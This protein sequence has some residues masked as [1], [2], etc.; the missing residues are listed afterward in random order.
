MLRSVGGAGESPIGNI[1]YHGRGK[2]RDFQL[3]QTSQELHNAM[4][5]TAQGMEM[6]QTLMVDGHTELDH[7]GLALFYEKI[8]GISLKK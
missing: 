4:P 3:L 2:R 8:N 5:L 6:M 7:S 1:G